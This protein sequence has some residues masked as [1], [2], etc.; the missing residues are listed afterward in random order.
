M[1]ADSEQPAPIIITV[2][3]PRRAMDCI[4]LRKASMSSSSF[5]LNLYHLTPILWREGKRPK[6]L[7]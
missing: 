1:P 5:V 7:N 6:N 2:I 4:A 3:R